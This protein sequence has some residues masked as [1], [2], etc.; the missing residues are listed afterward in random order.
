MHVGPRAGALLRQAG[1]AA[2]YLIALMLFRQ[3]SV[4]HWILLTGFHLAAL[5]LV[6]YRYWPALFAGDFAR[7]AYISVSCLDQYGPLWA[8]ANSIPSIAYEAPIVW[9][10]RER[11]HLFPAKGAVN[12]VAFVACALVIAAIATVEAI[13][14]VQLTPLPAGYDIQYGEVIARLMLGNF[15]GVLTITPFAL[16]IYQSFVAANHRASTWV[17]QILDSRLF[18]ESVFMVVPTLGF[19][20]WI[21]EHDDH[22]RTV[23]QMAMFLPVIVMAFRHG[24]QGGAIAGTMASI[25]TVLLMPA[26]NDHATLQAETMVAM[27]ISTMLLVGARLSHLDRRAEEERFDTRMAMALAQRNVALGEAQ[28][29]VT[30]QALDQLRDSINGV[31]GM[32]LGRLRHL[33][34]VADDAGYRRQAQIAQEQIYLLTDCLSPS[35]LRER[36][37]PAA[38]AHGSLAHTLHEAG[39]KYWCDL[40]GPV[41]LFPQSMTLAVYRMTCEAIADAL[42]TRDASDVLVKIR[43]GTRHGGWIVLMIETRRHPVRMQHVDWALAHRLRASA[44]GMGRKAIEDRAATF[45]GQVR[46]RSLRHGRRLIA[47]LHEPHPRD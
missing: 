29:R 10:F 19:L 41:S 31:F 37:L 35:Q 4:P 27:A 47:S 3:V 28:L 30:A 20:A 43:C 34:P 9:W 22:T 11:W 17:H 36:G 2:I 1:V 8:V 39:V 42:L 13:G 12:M 18:L 38:L 26:T 46:E 33:Q 40:R 16:V 24:W 32:M 21:G 23:A 25:G 7:L 6:P 45:G 14:Q 44:T 5:M 15:M